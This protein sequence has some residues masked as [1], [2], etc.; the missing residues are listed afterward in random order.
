MLAKRMGEH[1]AKAGEAAALLAAAELS[2]TPE[3]GQKTGKGKGKAKAK[4]KAKIK[5][6][7]A[8][9]AATNRGKA[10]TTNRG[11]ALSSRAAAGRM[12]SRTSKEPVVPEL[13]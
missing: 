9:K 12:S 11:R 5:V 13:N 8:S 3:K 1:E 4:A 7:L 2:A 10:K 6:P